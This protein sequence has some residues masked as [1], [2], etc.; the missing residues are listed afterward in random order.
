VTRT[1]L[2][3]SNAASLV[4]LPAANQRQARSSRSLGRFTM[5]T[6]DPNSAGCKRHDD[7]TS[8]SALGTAGWDA[9]Q[10]PPPRE[11]PPHGFCVFSF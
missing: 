9:G 7:R 2:K 10:V 5:A 4:T 1:E 8:D 6:N 11:D 3:G